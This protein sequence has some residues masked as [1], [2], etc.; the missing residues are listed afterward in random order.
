[1]PKVRLLTAWANSAVQYMTQGYLDQAARVCDT[2]AKEQPAGHFGAFYRFEDPAAALVGRYVR[3]RTG[4]APSLTSVRDLL[5]DPI[6]NF[7][8]GLILSAE[9]FARQENPALAARQILRIRPGALPLYT[10]GFSLWMNRLRELLDD[11]GGGLDETTV[12]KL[13]SLKR[14]LGKWDRYVDLTSPTVT[15]PGAD[16]SSPQLSPMPSAGA[17]P[18]P[19]QGWLPIRP[20]SVLEAVHQKWEAIKLDPIP[21]APAADE[22]QQEI[23]TQLVNQIERFS[24]ACIQRYRRIK[25]AGNLLTML[26]LGA[27]WGVIAAGTYGRHSLVVLFAATSTA[28]LA[29]NRWFGFD[30]RA[31]RYRILISEARIL[32]TEAKNSCIPAPNVVRRLRKLINDRA[33]ADLSW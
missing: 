12:S 15:F 26:G 8:D 2:A 1:M 21:Q 20:S 19:S 29:M 7:A 4:A 9:I 31:Q 33:A 27:P 23:S 24:A 30:A 17:E 6:Q 14:T 28:V 5:L 22:K 10:D 18:D 25:F 11:D 32:A 16:A 3:L 13:R